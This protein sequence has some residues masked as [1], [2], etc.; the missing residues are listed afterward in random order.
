M[1]GIGNTA[2]RRDRFFDQFMIGFISGLHQPVRYLIHTVTSTMDHV[3]SSSK[4]ILRDWAQQGSGYLHS[5]VALSDDGQLL[6]GPQGVTLS[7]TL[8][9]ELSDGTKSCSYSVASIY[10]QIRDP[11][12][13][14]LA[15]R[16]VCKQYQVNDPVK[17][18]DKPIVLRYFL[19]GSASESASAAPLP[20]TTPAVTK[21]E[22]HT[23]ER[24]PSIKA[25]PDKDASQDDQVK[26]P[27]KDRSSSKHKDRHS[28]RHHHDG[29][30]K[31]SSRDPEPTPV[32]KQPRSKETVTN[33]Q[34]FSNLNVVVDKR[35]G[36]TTSADPRTE[37]DEDEERN[38]NLDVAG[39]AAAA[40]TSTTELL[41]LHQQ[42]LIMMEALSTT[43]FDSITSDVLAQYNMPSA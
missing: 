31:S 11:D 13:G 9:L 23:S 38:E 7:A 19:E 33:E 30:R 42:Q 14:L 24:Q 5:A 2:L 6:Q 34:L 15:Y 4:G 28:S 3:E 39:N 27:S 25:E 16:N 17:A 26:T 43:G 37:G 21:E 41:Q 20:T 32:K 18:I 22:V 35:S 29:K 36:P 10:L 40:A 1:R 8:P 12:Q